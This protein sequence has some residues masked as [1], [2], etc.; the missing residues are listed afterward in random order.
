MWY[1][2]KKIIRSLTPKFI[3]SLY[4]FSLSFL[5]A[6]IYGFPA[7]DI[8]IIGITGTKGKTTI[9]EIVNHIL[10][11]YNFKTALVNSLRFKIG[12]EVK[13]NKM[14]MTM[15]GRFFLQKF[16][17]NALKN[18]CRFAILEVSSVGIEQHRH[19]FLNFDV[20]VFNN[21]HPEHL[22]DHCNSFEKYRK[23]KEKLFQ[24]LFSKRKKYFIFDRK[25][26]LELPFPK[27]SIVNLDDKCFPYFLKYWADKKIGYTLNKNLSNENLDIII[28][29]EKIDSS[30]SE[31]N[32]SLDD[33]DFSSPLLGDFNLSNILAS[34][35]V[36]MAIEI[37]LS[38][39]KESIKSFSNLPGRMEEIKEKQNFRIFV[40]FAHTPDS[41]EL[42]YKILRKE[43]K[44][45]GK[46]IGI[47]GGTGGGRD[48]WKRPVM[49]KIAGK[50]CDK[51]IITNEDPY[52]EDPL[53]IIQ[54]VAKGLKSIS[55]N[56]R[57]IRD[58]REAIAEALD[59]CQK[60]D[61][62]IITGKGAEQVMAIE[63][64]KKIPWDDRE[65]IKEELRKLK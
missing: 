38:I 35:S 36:G 43:L 51:V 20:V 65:V 33:I 47:I 40:D 31:I 3:L 58:R 25:G 24:S 32:F 9:T 18:N 53:K 37:P 45:G 39:I 4:H 27:T 64:N 12:S 23:A 15:P 29:P 48:K 17:K 61:I 1:Q 54:D 21:I 46:L 7:R 63:K 60:D 10:E 55:D 26:K 5:G 28:S 22:E 13:D 42:V 49:G 2:L 6:L 52:D 56:Y 16:L 34:I 41:L 14:K 44:K 19:R 57:I 30:N 8:I 62:L 11:S 50:Y 59:I